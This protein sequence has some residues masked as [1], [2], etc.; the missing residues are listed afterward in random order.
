MSRNSVDSSD[1]LMSSAEQ[2]KTILEEIYGKYF[3]KILLR[4][5]KNQNMP[6]QENGRKETYR[7]RS[8]Q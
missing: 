3:K 7:Q 5:I 4:L 8:L 2:S 1:K 6:L